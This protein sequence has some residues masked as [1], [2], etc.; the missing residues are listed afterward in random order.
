[1]SADLFSEDTN[2]NNQQKLIFARAAALASSGLFSE[3]LVYENNGECWFGG[4]VKRSVTLFA[5]RLE[6]E[7]ATGKEIKQVHSRQLCQALEQ[8]LKGWDGQWQACGWACFELA[9]ALNSP[10]LL[11]EEEKIGQ[12]PLLFVC[13]PQVSVCLSGNN[14]QVTGASKVLEEKLHTVIQSA[15]FHEPECAH[16]VEICGD[17]HY[18]DA[19]SQS[20]KAIRNETLDKVILSRKVP[21]HFTPDYISTWLKGRLNNTPARS[22]TMALP[23]WKATGFSPEIVLS[24]DAEGEVA[25]QP[26]A[27]TRRMEGDVQQD[28]NIFNE[29]F[30]DPK[31]T[32]EHAISVRLSVDEMEAVCEPESVSVRQF[33]T[34]KQRGSVQH[35]ASKV[36]GK[37]KPECNSWHAF[38]SLFPAVT[39]S[40]IQ[41]Q[42][43]FSEIRRRELSSRGLYAG[44]VMR[45]DHTGA[46]DAALVL[47][48]IIGKGDQSWLQA[49]AG[50]VLDSTPQR[51]LTETSEKLASIS[52]WVVEK[53]G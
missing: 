37:L 41:K 32:H 36:G 29:L 45:L 23:G 52:P 1:M 38:E 9:Y 49:G 15:V 30:K 19:V 34:R 4:G 20:V 11:N 47:R 14:V 25:T 44:A 35:L 53:R 3:Y 18:M 16:G 13:E 46:M 28:I 2:E 22:Y 27:G 12:E 8:E 21:L 51:E 40:G 42:A 48:S 33:M 39:A 31:E 5:D 17:S 6:S 50:V 7:S 43:A 10:E 26:L 24:V